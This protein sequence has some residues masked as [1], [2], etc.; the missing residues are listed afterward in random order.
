MQNT[1]VGVAACGGLDQLTWTARHT[2]FQAFDSATRTH[3]VEGTSIWLLVGT[4][5]CTNQVHAMPTIIL[6]WNSYPQ[7]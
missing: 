3:C 6:S 5:V 7:S 4:P 2:F 1:A